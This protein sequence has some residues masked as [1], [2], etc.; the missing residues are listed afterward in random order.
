MNQ[1]QK[2]G[3]MVLGAW[4]MAVGITI[5]QFVTPDIEAQNNGVFDKVVCREL[6][7][8][9][10]AG[11][12]GVRLIA[13]DKVNRVGVFDKLGAI[14]VAVASF[15][16][17]NGIV[18]NNLQ[19]NAGILLA[20]EEKGNSVDVH[21]PN[22]HTPKGDKVGVRLFCAEVAN[23]IQLT[24]QAGEESMQ[25]FAGE[26]RAPFIIITDRTGKNMWSTP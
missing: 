25:L 10:K 12:V 16:G 23:G 5:G 17:M 24:E 19:G 15:E 7:V 2:L 1:K 11:L 13:N 4:I 3:Y 26:V 6:E 18:V 22:V 14:A 8:V 20:S 9:D 21:T